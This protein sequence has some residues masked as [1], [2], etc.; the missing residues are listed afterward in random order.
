MNIFFF[1]SLTKAGFEKEA[2]KKC[3]EV[4]TI[5][6]NNV[7]AYCDRAEAYIKA[8]QYNDGKWFDQ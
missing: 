5:D 6:S 4:L 2:I 1:F 7:D 3:S 8:T